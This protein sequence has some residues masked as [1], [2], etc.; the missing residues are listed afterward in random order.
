MDSRITV[1]GIISLILLS[2]FF[3]SCS[4]DQ[5]QDPLSLNLKEHKNLQMHI[6][7][8][9]EIEILGEKQIIPTDIGISEGMMR[10]IHTHGTDGKLHIEA[11]MPHQFYLGDFFTIWGKTFTRDCIF[12]QCVDTEH[13]LLLL[14]DGQPSDLYEGLPLKDGQQIKIVYKEKS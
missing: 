11:P 2:L 14:V 12:E 13:E 8:T 4:R 6:H 7:P 1:T 5:P 9:L 10:V 3:I